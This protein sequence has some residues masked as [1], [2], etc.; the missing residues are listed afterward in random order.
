MSTWTLIK[1]SLITASIPIQ[2]WLAGY[3]GL[4]L[5]SVAIIAGYLVHSEILWIHKKHM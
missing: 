1:N 5:I 2:L 3:I 4:A